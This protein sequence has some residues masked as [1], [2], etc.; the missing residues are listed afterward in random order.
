VPQRDMALHDAGKFRY[1]RCRA[2]SRPSVKI[3]VG[4]LTGVQIENN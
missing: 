2:A 1:A 3:K 4:D